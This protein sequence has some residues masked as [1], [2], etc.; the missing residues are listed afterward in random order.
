MSTGTSPSIAKERVKRHRESPLKRVNP[1]G[2]T[3]WVARYTGPD[4]KRR[5][6]GTFAKKGPCAEQGTDCCAQHAI[7]AAY[8]IKTTT[9]S[10]WSTIGGYAEDWTERYPRSE[11]T[12]RTNDSRLKQVLDAP[13][14]GR[15]LHDWAWADIRRKHVLELVKHMLVREGR[16]AAGASNILRTLSAMAEDAYTDE[17]ADAN[18][19]Q[20]VAVRKSDRRVRKA[21]RQPQIL[22]WE[23]MHKLAAA[24][25]RNEA[26]L[27]ML[28]DCGLRIGELFALER[29]AQDL[30]NGIFRVTGSGWEGQFIESS[31]EKNHEREGPIPA[32]CLAI[33]RA[34][35]RRLDSRWLFSTPG[36]AHT[37]M[38]RIHWPPEDELRAMVAASGFSAVGR[39]LGVSDNAVRK[40]LQND[41]PARA[42]DDPAESGGLMWRY[43]NWYR[44]VW[45]PARKAS[46]INAT[47]HD[48]RHSWVTHLAAA[49]GVDETDLA[50]IAGHG[51]AVQ[52]ERYRHPLRRSFDAIRDAIG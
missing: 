44:D 6:A 47:P 34:A 20:G 24:A 41:Y 25:G 18:P 11:R 35:P 39:S 21:A 16:A 28:A 1:S 45:L 4:G 7:D 5:S 29:E 38:P 17:V 23:Q 15:L 30:K 27:R 50:A 8:G 31:P 32:R 52:Q 40:H 36:G 14:E 9:T 12:D 48:F 43:S 49:H 2:K 19:F 22:T 37:R 33:V 51:L 13:V 3:V 42:N 26:M 46:G 10:N